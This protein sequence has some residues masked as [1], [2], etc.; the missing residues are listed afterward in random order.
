MPW[1]PES[2]T[3]DQRRAAASAIVQAQVGLDRL[4]RH[5]FGGESA[6][7]VDS[8]YA[9]A[10]DPL[11]MLYEDLFGFDRSEPTGPTP[12]EPARYPGSRQPCSRRTATQ[13]YPLRTSNGLSTCCCWRRV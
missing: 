8:V 13:T 3:L 2:F 12:A 4:D 1:D 11:A 10:D 7:L 6:D 5:Q 9:R